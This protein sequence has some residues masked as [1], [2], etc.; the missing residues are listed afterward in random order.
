[1]SRHAFT[2]ER[3][4]DDL[5]N[6]RTSSRELTEKALASI[7]ENQA[8]GGPVFLTVDREQALASA[9]YMDALRKAGR[10]PCAFAGIPFSAKDLFDQ[11]G[12]VTK[13][14]SV[15]RKDDAP[16]RCDAVAIGRL[17]LAGF[18][19]L[20]RTNMTEFA[21]SGVGL[22]PHY[23]T[24]K[25]IFDRKTGRIPGG[26]SAGAAISVADGTCA[27]GIGTDTGGSC[28]VPAAFNGIVGY[29]P[30]HGRI[31]LDGVFPLAATFDTVGPLAASVQ[32]CATSDAIM[33]RDWD[34]VIPERPL[35]GMRLGIPQSLVLDDLDGDV[36]M[37]FGQA[38]TRLACCGVE[39]V[40]VEFPELDELASINAGGGIG[41]VEAY[42]VHREWL[43]TVGDDFDPRVRVRIL[44]GAGVTAAD[45]LALKRQRAEMIVRAD[46]LMDGLD[47]FI[48][49][50]CPQIPAEISALNDD[51]DYG[52][53]NLLALRNT[54]VGNFLN[55]CAISIPAHEA[56]NAPVGLMLMAPLMADS[57]LFSVAK[58][59]E[60]IVS[61]QAV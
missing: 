17:K 12:Q 55:R 41:A 27:L 40:D 38:L 34:G 54:F 28:R 33:A 13:A 24:P 52:R 1:M 6:N 51:A 18:V 11:A 56:G 9:D 19:A 7:G 39:L 43:E 57:A 16:A 50:T 44:A 53:I 5:A 42:D 25:S 21:Y 32:C 49:P 8:W 36:A 4:A 45:F 31:P 35:K 23:G 26:S 58:A 61:P 47:G 59:V 14:G 15:V 20:G 60:Q 48:M 30:S 2:L 22:N 37:V 29:K 46:V 10:E 3:L